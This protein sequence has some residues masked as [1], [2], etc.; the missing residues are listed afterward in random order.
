V[1]Y[2]RRMEDR[3]WQV[4]VHGGRVV[5]RFPFEEEG[6][7]VAYAYSTSA[8]DARELA[9]AISAAADATGPAED[10]PPTFERI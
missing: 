10:G 9:E 2:D 5:V 6:D 7:G 8:D 1:D 4:S 3:D